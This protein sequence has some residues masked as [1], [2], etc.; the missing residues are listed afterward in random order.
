MKLKMKKKQINQT[1]YIIYWTRNIFQYVHISALQTNV[2]PMIKDKHNTK[3]KM[4][5]MKFENLR[6]NSHNILYI[7]N[8]EVTNV[9]K[10]ILY[11]VYVF[12]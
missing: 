3:L 9:Y 10:Y 11:C 2:L 1:I 5:M 12:D 6:S 4:M 8:H 7:D